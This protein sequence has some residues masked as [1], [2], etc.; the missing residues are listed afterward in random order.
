MT[1]PETLTGPQKAAV[2][3]LTLGV[4]SAAQI[5]KQLE[6]EEI[7]A[8]T[9]EIT[10]MKSVSAKASTAVIEEFQQMAR[11]QEFMSTGGIRY[12]QDVL[13]KA[14]GKAKASTI[15]ERLQGLK[16]ANFFTAL[17]KV[18]P[19][20]LLDS[21]RQEHPQTIAVVLSH[22]ESTTSAG[23][24]AGLPHAVRADVVMRIANMD[25]TNPDLIG[26]IERILDHRLSSVVNQEVS[27][28]GGVKQVAEILNSM[29]RNSE[30]GVFQVIQESDPYMADEIRKLMFT[31]DDVVLVDDRG[32]QRVLKEVEQKELALAMKAAGSE[33][34]DKLF[35]NMS[36]RAGALLKEEIEYLGPV[37]LRDV[38]AAQQKVVAIVRR[39]DEAG[40]IIVQ[41]RGGGA[42]EIIV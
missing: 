18:E 13:E 31:F 14:V 22:L 21:V 11:A 17:K 40:E 8:I 34:A 32:I 36:E 37:K 10:R 5:F 33:V 27:I 35:R 30:R 39:L 38:E 41:G 3:L 42:E 4:E 28:S 29:D 9:G 25:K 16:G 1:A 7:E 20:F 15:I 26:E 23:V 19:R 24:L 2:L 6:D 12:A